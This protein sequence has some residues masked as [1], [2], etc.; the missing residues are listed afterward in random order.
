MLSMARSNDIKCGRGTTRVVV[1]A[2]SY[3]AA[4][5]FRGKA[6]SQQYRLISIGNGCSIQQYNSDNTGNSSNIGSNSETTGD[7]TNNQVEGMIK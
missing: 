2:R 1:T 7:N 3:D 4:V 6:M 5:A